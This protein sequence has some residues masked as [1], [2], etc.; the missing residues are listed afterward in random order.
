M[1]L[2]IITPLLIFLA[3]TLLLLFL[4][5]GEKGN[6]IHY[7]F[8]EER[9]TKVSGPFESSGSTSRYALTEAIVEDHTLFLNE[10]RA[11]FSAPDMVE[12]NGRFFSIFTPGI[13]F[14]GV[15]FY[16]IG[17][18]I[19]LPQ[20]FTYLSTALLALLN[21]FLVSK[22]A[23]KLG[24]GV[25]ASLLSGFVFLFAT[26]ALSYA[27]TYTQHHAS[28]AI[29][30]LAL[31]NTFGKRSLL[32]NLWFG[33]LVGI[34]LLFDIP[35]ILI[36]TPIGLYILIRHFQITEGKKTIKVT[37]KLSLISLIIG[38]IPLL[39]L[40]GWYNY[41]LTNSWTKIGQTIG[42]SDYFDPPEI[43]QKHRQE[44]KENLSGWELPFYTRKQLT[45]LYILLLSNQRGWIFYSPVVFIGLLGLILRYKEYQKHK[46]I[47]VSTAVV[48]TTIVTYS[49]FGGLGG[50]EFGP[51]YL[52][53]AAA[54]LC[55]SL[56]LALQ[57]FKKNIAFLILFSILSAYSIGV[58]AIGAMTTTQ[59]PPKVEAVNLIEPIPYTYEY[60]LQLIDQNKNSSLA[61]NLFLSDKLESWKFIYGYYSIVLL[62]AAGLYMT[63]VFEK[64]A[65]GGP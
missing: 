38:I 32:K 64:E 54:I 5:K 49:M 55:A 3:M 57:R 53:P 13:S 33:A 45:G 46:V 17:K 51:R 60:N 65:K 61:Y 15:P 12:Y 28:T 63:S 6:P 37:L 16:L 41:Q 31:L 48:L 21:V 25:Y 24:A 43:R 2:K 30:L 29:I 9:D 58:N 52:I 14:I 4:I 18:S 44:K 11:R 7:Q 36:M 26:N 56:G 1:K 62:A 40:F 22:L 42:Q 35:N 10:D 23:R 47:I 50:W 59:V 34:G 8:L 19:G 27:L 39:A 20:L